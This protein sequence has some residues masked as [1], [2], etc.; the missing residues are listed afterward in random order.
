[1]NYTPAVITAKVKRIISR[2]AEYKEITPAIYDV[3]KIIQPAVN[4]LVAEAVYENILDVP[5]KLYS[6]TTVINGVNYYH[7]VPQGEEFD[8]VEALVYIHVSDDTDLSGYEGLLG[9]PQVDDVKADARYSA[10]WSQTKANAL[11]VTSTNEVLVKGKLAPVETKMLYEGADAAEL[12][13]I[14][15]GMSKDLVKPIKSQPEEKIN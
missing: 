14:Y 6:Q 12:T 11:A 13:D 10:H 7:L 8:G 5:F 15:E 4:E 9:N 1:M 2:P 3:E